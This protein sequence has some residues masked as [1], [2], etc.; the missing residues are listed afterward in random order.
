MPPLTARNGRSARSPTPD[1]LRI[2]PASGREHLDP[3]RRPRRRAALGRD[4]AGAREDL[5][6]TGDV[7][8]LHAGVGE[9][10]DRPGL[11]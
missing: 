5:E 2:G 4:L 9:H 11:G 6:R 10:R 1:A 8:D 7:Q 3:V